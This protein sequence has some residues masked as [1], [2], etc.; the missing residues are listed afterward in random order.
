MRLAAIQRP[1]PTA[2]SLS[3]IAHEEELAT[4]FESAASQIAGKCA[5]LTARFVENQDL[6]A[7]DRR[8]V[9]EAERKHDRTCLEIK[10]VR[11]DGQVPGSVQKAANGICGQRVAVGDRDEV[12][13]ELLL[14]ARSLAVG[15][16]SAV[17]G[18]VIREF[19]DSAGCLRCV[20]FDASG[21]HYWA[22]SV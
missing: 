17:N 2:H 21:K 12:L 13:D 3:Q 8:P 4:T 10:S 15:H 18:A 5:D 9:P 7:R 14:Q 16:R 1:R 22:D 6:I 19:N 20:A 11:R